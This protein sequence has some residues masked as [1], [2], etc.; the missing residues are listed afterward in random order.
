MMIKSDL[1]PEEH[2]LIQKSKDPSVIMT[3]NGTAH[4]T[5]EATEYVYNLDMIVQ[6]QL[7][8]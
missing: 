4:T 1:T 5:E 8:R 7:L 6:V 2:R 3:A